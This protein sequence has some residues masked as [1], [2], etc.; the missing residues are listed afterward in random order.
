MCVTLFVV[1]SRTFDTPF[2]DYLP[3][4]MVLSFRRVLWTPDPLED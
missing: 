4:E 1:R 2:N 3:P